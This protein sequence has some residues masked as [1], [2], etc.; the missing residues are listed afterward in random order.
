MGRKSFLGGIVLLFGGFAIGGLLA[1][2][3]LIGAV[4]P[5]LMIGAGCTLT[6]GAIRNLH[7]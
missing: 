5:V 7:N 2:M 3:T 6:V 1:P 4:F